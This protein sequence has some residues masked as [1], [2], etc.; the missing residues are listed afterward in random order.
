MGSIH[1]VSSGS[2]HL[3]LRRGLTSCQPTFA[4][5]GVA[6]TPR[7]RIPRTLGAVAGGLLG[8]ALLPAAAAFADDYGNYDLVPSS[9]DTA[10]AVETVE[11]GGVPNF[12]IELP[13]ALIGSVQ[14]TQE[15]DVDDPSNTQVGTVVADV[16]NTTVIVG[17]T[18]QEILITSDD[19]YTNVGTAAGNVPPVGSVFDTYTYSSDSSVVYS[20]I[21]TATGDQISFTWDTP[22]GDFD[23]PTSYDAITTVVP[24]SIAGAGTD[25]TGDSLTGATFVLSGTETVDGV[26][27]LPPVDYDLL[28]TQTFDVDNASG[29][30][31]GSFSVDVANSSDFAGN[32]TQDVLVTSSSGDAPA[33]GSVIDY[34]FLLGSH[35]SVYNVYSDIPSTTGGADT[36]TDTVVTPL[37]NSA[38]PI[39]FDAAAGLADELDGTSPV[40]TAIDLPND[41][42]ITPEGSGTIVGIDGIQPADIDVQGTQEFGYTDLATGQ[43]GTFDADVAQSTISFF[44]T[45]PQ[46]QLVVTSSSGDAPAVGSVFEIYNYGDGYESIYS[47]IPSTTGSNTITDTFV[48]PFG[49]FQIPDTYAAA[50]AFAADSSTNF[51]DPG[52]STAAADLL[53]SLDPSAAADTGAFVDLFPHLD[54][55]LNLLAGLF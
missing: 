12:L 40:G 49:D 1:E 22:F 20:D 2:S 11:D 6:P 42:D 25:A 28:G 30:Q 55:A 33:V 50:A 46:E 5:N 8:V 3:G 16:A 52:A 54:A 29:T 26:N 45:I 21:P 35:D 10:G 31:I 24:V 18:N 17:G 37:G 27:G 23:I 39:D 4:L 7:R 15:F 36:I 19:G 9:V 51:A 34:F 47:D 32:S 53:S 44:N 14:G 41:Y 38:I 48:T 13:P 43:T